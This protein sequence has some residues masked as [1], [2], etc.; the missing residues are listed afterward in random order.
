[1][2]DPLNILLADDDGDE[3]IL[4]REGLQ[5]LNL[6]HHVLHVSCGDDLFALLE[7]RSDI[8][9]LVIDIHMPG[10]N[11]IECLQSIKRHQ[12]HKDMP[13]IMMTVSKNA[14]DIADVYAAGAH[15][16]VIKPYSQHNYAET[17]RKIFSVDWKSK[18]PVPS[19]D[20]FVINL[21]FA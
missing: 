18:P 20:E 9:L 1:M 12:Q 5:L 3:A 4:F 10:Q 15:H 19:R 16:Y 8:D 14:K 11:G 2:T 13:V 6:P 7:Q 21:A 17:L